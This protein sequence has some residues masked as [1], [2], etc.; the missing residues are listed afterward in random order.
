MPA[1]NSF[2]LIESVKLAYSIKKILI[3]ILLIL[4]PIGA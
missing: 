4:R 1:S 2:R 3:S